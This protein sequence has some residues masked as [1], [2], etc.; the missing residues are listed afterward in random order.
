MKTVFRSNVG[1]WEAQT[2]EGNPEI[3]PGKMRLSMVRLEVVEL[4]ASNTD[5][6][7]QFTVAAGLAEESP[8]HRRLLLG[9]RDHL[10]ANFGPGNPTK[11]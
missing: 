3:P 6:N 10:V 7:T 8:E 2:A 1:F 11:R 4:D 5:L 9:L